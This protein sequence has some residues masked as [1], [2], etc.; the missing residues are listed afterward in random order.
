MISLEEF[1]QDFIQSIL[2]DAE[3]RGLLQAKS[4]FEN[5]CEELITTA[6]LTNNY[7]EAEYTRKGIDVY[8]Y[9]YDEERKVLSLLS[10][11]FFQED[12][13][14]AIDPRTIRLMKPSNISMIE[15]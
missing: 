10:H 12:I 1:H 13:A 11:E 8:G 3:S 15:F 4:F 7:T 9:D 5:V 2:S 14:V 6:D